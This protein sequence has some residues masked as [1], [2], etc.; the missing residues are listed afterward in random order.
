MLDLGAGSGLVAIAAALA[1]AGAVLASEIDPLAHAAI[2]LNAQANGVSIAILGDVLGGAGEDAAVVLAADVWYER[3][4]AAR[5]ADLLVRAAARGS[6]ILAADVGR[7]FLPKDL[8]RAIA[9]YEVPVIADLEDADVKR[10]RI[11]TL[12]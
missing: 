11:L 1:G 4:L 5:T 7:A 3:H 2:R 12:A 10:V 6:H 8:F 9:S